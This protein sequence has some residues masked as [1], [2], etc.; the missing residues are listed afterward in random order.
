MTDIIFNPIGIVHSPFKT[1]D[2][3]PV[4]PRFAADAAGEIEIFEGLDLKWDHS[5][6]DVEEAS[7]AGDVD[8]EASLS[9]ELEGEVALVEI[10]VL[11]VWID[12]DELPGDR[13]GVVGRQNLVPELH[14]IAVKAVQRQIP[15]LE[16]DV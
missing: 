9:G 1:K 16:V 6:H 11:T 13:L 3:C 7:L 14:E 2:D 4:Q 12:F 5:Q 15:H 10:E 8:A